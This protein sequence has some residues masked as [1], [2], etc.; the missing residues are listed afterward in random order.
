[1]LYK[2]QYIRDMPSVRTDEQTPTPRSNLSRLVAYDGS[3]TLIYIKQKLQK[4]L[5]F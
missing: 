1:M 3:H 4:F 2:P 5:F